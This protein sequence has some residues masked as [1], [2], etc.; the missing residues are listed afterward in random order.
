M[1][2]CLL[3]AAAIY[4]IAVIYKASD[5]PFIARLLFITHSREF[6][7]EGKRKIK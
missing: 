1:E 2:L 3:N 7:N 4:Y 6:D 5:A